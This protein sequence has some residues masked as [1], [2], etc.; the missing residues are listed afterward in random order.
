MATMA[1]DKPAY[2]LVQKIVFKYDSTNAYISD[3]GSK[4][5]G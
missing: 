3:V 2:V 1:S 4:H 5:A